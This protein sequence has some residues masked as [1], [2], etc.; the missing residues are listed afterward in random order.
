MTPK[1]VVAVRA[2]SQLAPRAEPL[3]SADRGQHRP[4]AS[5]TVAARHR[6]LARRIVERQTDYVGFANDFRVP[7]DN[8]AAERDFACCAPIVPPP[9]NTVAGF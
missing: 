5:D 1:R 3:R 6:V 7:F 8:G 9:P 4:L 2:G